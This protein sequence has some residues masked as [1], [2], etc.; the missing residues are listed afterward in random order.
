M[1]MTGP[2]QAQQLGMQA[3]MSWWSDN[4]ELTVSFDRS[5]ESSLVAW[6]KLNRRDQISGMVP[7]FD[8]YYKIMQEAFLSLYDAESINPIYQITDLGESSIIAMRRATGIGLDAL[9][10]PAAPKL[11]ADDVLRAQIQ[12][13]WVEISG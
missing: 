11:S 10:A 5:L 2:N 9:P 12:K 3:S 6:V 8:L 1:K 7:N 4:R 13:D